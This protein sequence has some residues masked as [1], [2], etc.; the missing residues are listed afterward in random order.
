M[1]AC[2]ATPPRGAPGYGVAPCAQQEG[3]AAMS[4]AVRLSAFGLLLLALLLG[5][6]A[7]G[8]QLGPLTTNY[9]RSGAPGA[10]AQMHMGPV[11][12]PVSR[13]QMSEHRP[14]GGSGR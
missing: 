2:I 3:R 4:P 6:R 7:V 8:A 10:P 5:A 1:S 13:Y 9:L 14:A 11:H 12:A